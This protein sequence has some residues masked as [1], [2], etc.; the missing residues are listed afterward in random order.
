MTIRKILYGYQIQ[1][2]ELAVISQEA[3][4][5]RRITTLYLAGASYQKIS[6]SLN[7]DGMPD[8]YFLL[9]LFGGGRGTLKAPGPP[10]FWL[11]LLPCQL[12]SAVQDRGL[13]HTLRTKRVVVVAL[14]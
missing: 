7:G 11:R 5:V 8:S 13:S 14:L 1:R 10:W 3:E 9:L 6:A 2:G 4:T 12:W